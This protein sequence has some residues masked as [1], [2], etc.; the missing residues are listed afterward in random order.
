M[1][2]QYFFLGSPNNPQN[3]LLVIVSKGIVYSGVHLFDCSRRI[4]FEPGSNFIDHVIKQSGDY[5]GKPPAHFSWFH[6]FE[7]RD[8]AKSVKNRYQV[9]Q[10]EIGTQSEQGYFLR[11]KSP[12]WEYWI[13]AGVRK[14]LDDTWAALPGNH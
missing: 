2:I 5:L 8:P 14:I 13:P 9:D 10:L 6:V 12:S 3:R 4:A 1:K 11:T 7:A